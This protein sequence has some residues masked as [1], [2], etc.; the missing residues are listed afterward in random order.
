M[1]NCKLTKNNLV[2]LALHEVS[3]EQEQTLIAQMD[4][5]ESCREEY[6][7]IKGALSMTR[8]SM[9]AQL[10]AENFWSGYHDRLTHSLQTPRINQPRP[11][12]A[13]RAWLTLKAWATSSV[14]VPV[15]IAAAVLIM[16]GVAV[17][18][19]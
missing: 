5:C 16:F 8:A 2:E 17:T 11:T 19:F 10:P 1:H 6:A 4:H 15:P 13:E 12:M 7:A 14:R 18:T 3:L 9:L